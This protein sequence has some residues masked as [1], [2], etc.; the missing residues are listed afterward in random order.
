LA[1]RANHHH[2]LHTT[3]LV[4]HCKCNKVHTTST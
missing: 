1:I 4:S 3:D 2:W